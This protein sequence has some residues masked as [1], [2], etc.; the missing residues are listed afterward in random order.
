MTRFNITLK[1][2]VFI[3]FCLKNERRRNFCSK[4]P[5]YKILDVLKAI[6]LIKKL[7]RLVLDRVDEEMITEKIDKY[8]RVQEL[9]RYFAIIQKSCT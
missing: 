9:F 7:L 3:L 6:N 8:I 2:L 4:I 5:S 1:E